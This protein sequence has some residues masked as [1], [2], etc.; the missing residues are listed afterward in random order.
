MSCRI[1]TTQNI[2][3]LQ[4]SN[5]QSKTPANRVLL[6][7]D[8]K[9]QTVTTGKKL[10]YISSLIFQQDVE[11]PLN[12]LARNK[13]PWV[14]FVTRN[15]LNPPVTSYFEPSFG[16]V[17]F[18]DQTQI[19]QNMNNLQDVGFILLDSKLK[20]P[21]P[22]E[23]SNSETEVTGRLFLTDLFTLSRIYMDNVQF[24]FPELTAGIFYQNSNPSGLDTVE[25]I[26][27]RL[28]INSSFEVERRFWPIDISFITNAPNLRGGNIYVFG[29]DPTIMDTDVD[30]VDSQVIHNVPFEL[31]IVDTL[32]EQLLTIN[33]IY[34]T[35]I[36]PDN[37]VLIGGNFTIERDG[38]VVQSLLARVDN[39]GFLDP[40][41][42]PVV[43]GEVSNPE[44]NSIIFQENKIIIA[45][46]FSVV[47][48]V[49]SGNIARINMDGS[50]DV[51]FNSN[52]NGTIE[53]LAIQSDNKI[54]VGG[55]FT[56]VNGIE[57]G[58]L[59]RIN[60]D[61]D[62]D[63]TFLNPDLGWPTGGATV[64]DIKIQ[65]NDRILVTGKFE[66]S[67]D[68]RYI[69]RF[70]PTGVRESAPSWITPIIFN[71]TGL[72]APQYNKIARDSSGN[73]FVTG[74]SVVKLKSTGE[75]ITTFTQP[76]LGDNSV[77][78]P[79]VYS[80]HVLNNS[81]LLIGGNFTEINGDPFD[82]FAILDINTGLPESSF[83]DTSNTDITDIKPVR[84]IIEDSSGNIYVGGSGVNI[85]VGGDSV[86][87]GKIAR[88]NP[89]ASQSFIYEIDKTFGTEYTIRHAIPIS[90][91]EFVTNLVTQPFIYYRLFVN[92][93][94][95]VNRANFTFA[96]LDHNIRQVKDEIGT[97][98]TRY[99]LEENVAAGLPNSFNFKDE[100]DARTETNQIGFRSQEVTLGPF[101]YNEI[102]QS[103]RLKIHLID[104]VKCKLD[105]RLIE[106]EIY[107]YIDG[108]DHNLNPIKETIRLKPYLNFHYFQDG[109]LY[110]YPVLPL[111]LIDFGHILGDI[112]D[113]NRVP[114]ELRLIYQLQKLYIEGFRT[115]GSS[116]IF[117]PFQLL[118]GQSEQYYISSLFG[119][120][121]TFE[122]FYITDIQDLENIN[123][124]AL[125][126]N[127][128]VTYSKDQSRTISDTEVFDNGLYIADYLTLHPKVRIIINNDGQYIDPVTGEKIELENSINR[129]LINRYLS[130]NQLENETEI[131]QFKYNREEP[132]VTLDG[133][134]V[135]PLH[136]VLTPDF[137]TGEQFRNLD[138]IEVV[139][140]ICI[141]RDIVEQI[142]IDIDGVNLNIKYFR[143]SAGPTTLQNGF[144][145]TNDV[146]LDTDTREL[147]DERTLNVSTSIRYI[148][149]PQK[150]YNEFVFQF[151]GQFNPDIEI[152]MEIRP[153]AQTIDLV[154]EDLNVGDQNIRN[155]YLYREGDPRYSNFLIEDIYQV[156][157]DVVLKSE[158]EF[159]RINNIR[160][161]SPVDYLRIER[162]NTREH[163]THRFYENFRGI[164]LYVLE[165]YFK[166]RF[167]EFDNSHIIIQL[168]PIP[169][170]NTILD[171]T[172]IK[173][174][175]VTNSDDENRQLVVDD[176]VPFENP[177][178]QL[179]N[180]RLTSEDTFYFTLD[181]NL[182]HNRFIIDAFNATNVRYIEN[183]RF[184]V[185]KV[186]C[187]DDHTLILLK[188]G[189][190]FTTGRN[191]HGQLG[192]GNFSNQDF[193][194][195][196]DYH[197]N[198]VPS[199]AL[200]IDIEAGGEHSMIR[201]SEGNNSRL[202]TFGNNSSGQL[203]L[204]D[205]ND[206]NIPTLVNFSGSMSSYYTTAISAGTNHSIIVFSASTLNM[207]TTGSNQYGQLGIG[208]AIPGANTFRPVL[209]I[210]DPLDN[211]FYQYS[212]VVD[213]SAG[214]YHNLTLI[215][216]DNFRPDSSDNMVDSS[217]G[218]AFTWGRNHMGQLGHGFNPLDDQD[219]TIPE[220]V[221]IDTSHNC[222]IGITSI[223]AGGE[224]TLY[225][226]EGEVYSFG[227]NEFG[228]LGRD[229]RNNI[230]L[231]VDVIT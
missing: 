213:I 71:T 231:K 21:R 148:L 203:G 154:K 160:L 25:T 206:R 121:S 35:L 209:Q 8:S 137:F 1:G 29:Q 81:K 214:W 210:L 63:P 112:T 26:N 109:K 94:E 226:S 192:I 166:S 157:K 69:V 61:G 181:K 218:I 16:T 78:K 144:T 184:E 9:Y 107:L 194:V 4:G 205:N 139:F 103:N 150:L 133:T 208:S 134:P 225:L 131:I 52:I 227:S 165:N 24:S 77:D 126:P 38:K 45:G 177:V 149:N 190:I 40:D 3:L 48:G 91:G 186:S 106:N 56:S 113:T 15:S 28:E 128:L 164:D 136:A 198:G 11:T 221:S 39:L 173:S 110:K 127:V 55:N 170:E 27:G 80:I 116:T 2:N 117:Q 211:E 155:A 114:E 176:Y 222:H 19:I 31:P 92:E 142:D 151:T 201:L 204:G 98:Y 33:D 159:W 42:N 196:V 100:L 101:G 30:L 223:S 216:P 169:R 141:I 189:D 93:P 146:I 217:N 220:L 175:H 83:L 57:R 104:P 219:K 59:A 105:P 49:R 123:N 199:S 118:D 87:V 51:T 88:F 182:P 132:F 72:P 74:P 102:R 18:Y 75:I 167:R 64:Y 12:K 156:S 130:S 43:E 207:A 62:I 145:L 180:K 68:R 22:G 50:T 66:I 41:F 37:K 85:D 111:A 97:Q 124:L 10:R 60:S 143:D 185:D 202:L 58:R 200:A 36:Q 17:T 161:S 140:K 187:G 119:E 188:N 44:I 76:I 224:H 163:F 135:L 197:V 153:V 195:P 147:V 178:K 70:L 95:S 215:V 6:D 13:Y 23:P 34:A 115:R 53:S 7:I 212:K 193:F 138:N 99:E 125:T 158:K 230:P 168:R 191:N 84:R 86:L 47:N 174:N 229:G 179:E 162:D 65:D 54:L 82:S 183:V 129:Y 120:N 46:Q 122:R 67:G 90:L 108:L 89:D 32:E 152:D 20:T 228:Q 171:L 14:P 96:D 79:L 73:I 5:N 172:Y